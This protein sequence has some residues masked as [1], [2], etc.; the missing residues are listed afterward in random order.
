MRGEGTMRFIKY[1]SSQ[2]IGSRWDIA[3]V[4]SI[5]QPEYDE[6]EDIEEE[7]EDD[8]DDEVRGGGGAAA[9]A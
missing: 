4:Y 5:E 3:T 8:D 1:V 6:D 7:E 9:D 2:A